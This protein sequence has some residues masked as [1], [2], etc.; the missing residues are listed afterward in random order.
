MEGLYS[1]EPG[2]ISTARDGSLVPLASTA[3]TVQLYRMPLVNPVIV[4][5]LALPVAVYLPLLD[6]QVIWY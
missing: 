6:S 2:V 5:G 1:G 3:V 4:I